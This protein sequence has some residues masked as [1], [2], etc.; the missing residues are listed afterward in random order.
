MW[1]ILLFW[2]C[3]GLSLRVCFEFDLSWSSKF[4]VDNLFK[5]WTWLHVND[6]LWD[7]DPTLFFFW[8]IFWFD[9]FVFDDFLH[10]IP[11]LTNFPI[12][13][14]SYSCPL[15]S[16][17]C[18]TYFLI[19]WNS[20]LNSKTGVCIVLPITISFFCLIPFLADFFLNWV[21]ASMFIWKRPELSII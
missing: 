5:T 15:F 20:L 10:G 16:I 6:Q 21:G 4:K 11:C 17:F 13:E 19:S 14:S 3:L 1:S 12:T 2:F 18:Y 8:V 9:R 7:P